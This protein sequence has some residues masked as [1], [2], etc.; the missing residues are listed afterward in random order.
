MRFRQLQ[1]Q[2]HRVAQQLQK[3]QLQRPRLP[4]PGS[5]MRFRSGMSLSQ[6]QQSQAPPIAHH[7]QLQP[8]YAGA[9]TQLSQL[10]GVLHRPP[11]LGHSSY[12][13]GPGGASDRFAF[14]PTSAAAA[15]SSFAPMMRFREVTADAWDPS[16]SGPFDHSAAPTLEHLPEYDPESSSMGFP[17]PQAAARAP[18]A[19]PSSGTWDE[20]FGARRA[21]AVPSPLAAASMHR[22]RLL[23][24]PA[25]RIRRPPTLPRASPPWRRASPAFLQT[26][27]RARV[28]RRPPVGGFGSEQPEDQ[29][30]AEAAAPAEQAGAAAG[31]PDPADSAPTAAADP[32]AAAPMPATATPGLYRMPE[33][34]GF[35]RRR[36]RDRGGPVDPY[37]RVPAPP[38]P[39]SMSLMQTEEFGPG[40]QGARTDISM[41]PLQVPTPKLFPQAPGGGFPQNRMW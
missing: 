11:L 39:Q 22:F 19:F 13:F 5:D 2:R 23:P 14:A 34:P 8:F 40:E 38:Q 27:A 6:L 24:L 12:S 37:N 28:S 36:S 32:S 4:L 7:T 35:A 31:T 25:N 21:A 3:Q 1:Q 41:N 20:V 26:A 18:A 33:P 9:P 30:Q 16:E 17:Q 10:Q 15:P 29:E